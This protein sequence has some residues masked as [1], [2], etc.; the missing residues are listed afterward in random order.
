MR[1]F[2]LLLLGCFLL[3]NF[4]AC[5]SFLGKKDDD[6]SSEKVL[7]T[8]VYDPAQMYGLI[9]MQCS[10]ATKSFK[11]TATNIAGAIIF[12]KTCSYDPTT[13]TSI[14]S[15]KR[16]ADGITLKDE[17][18]HEE[19]FNEAGR[20]L[21]SKTWVD[22]SKAVIKEEVSVFYN[23]AGKLSKIESSRIYDKYKY[24]DVQNFDADETPAASTATTFIDGVQQIVKEDNCDSIFDF[25]PRTCERKE[26]GKV[27]ETLT[28]SFDEI[29]KQELVKGVM[30]ETERTKLI[31]G[32]LGKHASR[33]RKSF[34][35]DGTLVSEESETCS[36][37][38]AQLS[39]STKHTGAD[40][41]VFY[42][43][44][45]VEED[46]G[47]VILKVGGRELP[48]HFF[49][50]LKG[51]FSLQKKDRNMSG[52]MTGASD[53]GTLNQSASINFTVAAATNAGL[54]GTYVSTPFWLETSS[55]EIDDILED[56]I[57]DASVSLKTK[58]IRDDQLR[59]TLAENFEL[60]GVETSKVKKTFRMKEVSVF[61]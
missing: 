54:D 43:E 52:S 36:Q 17:E 60:T 11:E 4:A 21:S 61:P 34:S 31:P 2:V 40:S 7:R 20:P 13:R 57:L 9:D 10:A 29:V 37:N 28:Y 53:P 44:N 41:K 39:C 16:S 1:R 14:G 49:V 19:V 8:V 42:T 12:E 33:L 59:E 32:Y 30:T 27:V 6:E 45:S 50:K 35:S 56:N 47:I 55:G 26:N 46:N 3:V 24:V 18:Y 5:G 25:S 51:D 23:E 58:V 38:G 22:S 48:I 15:E